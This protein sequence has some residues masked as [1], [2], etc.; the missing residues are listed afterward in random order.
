[1]QNLNSLVT[2][3]QVV[4]AGSF[5][6]AARRSGTAKSSVSKTVTKLEKDLGARLL[7]RNTRSL[8]LTEVGAALYEHCGRILEEIEQ[9][10]RLAAELHSEPRGT[11]KVSASVAFGTL[12]IS[13]A[14]PQFLAQNPDVKVDLT[15][16]DRFVDLAEDGFDLALRITREPDINLVARRLAPIRRKVCASPEY[17]R[18]HGVPRT[19]QDLSRHNCLHYTHMSVQGTWRFHGPDQ[20][21]TVPVSGNLRIND[22]EALSQAV[23]GGLGV[24]LLPTF[25]IGKDLQAGRLRAVLSEYVPIEQFVYAVYLPTRHIPSKVRAFI[26]FFVEKFGSTPYW[27][28]PE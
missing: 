26:D 17:F 10:E 4:D 2:F 7:N 21:V 1:M 23:L 15:I 5:S 12:H 8:S 6:E 19:P 3:A 24:A 25:I 14:L 18:K 27:D 9:A 28:L 22:D 13:P 16:R 11:I 20:D